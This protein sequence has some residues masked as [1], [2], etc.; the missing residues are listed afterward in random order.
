MSVSE[1]E[2][3]MQKWPFADFGYMHGERFHKPQKNDPLQ[4]R[5]YLTVEAVF[6]P[7]SETV[8]FLDHYSKEY[9]QQRNELD[10]Y[11]EKLA[12]EGWKLTLASNM[13]DGKAYYFRRYQF[14]RI[15]E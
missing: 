8:L 1:M 14:R 3:V 9:K 2:A 15:K 6:I 5:E 11:F 10:Q 7:A 13:L 12:A 4:K